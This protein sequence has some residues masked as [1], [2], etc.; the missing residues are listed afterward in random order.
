MASDHLKFSLRLLTLPCSLS[1]MLALRHVGSIPMRVLSFAML[2]Y[3]TGIHL[4]PPSQHHCK[5]SCRCI[6]SQ[7][8]SVGYVYFTWFCLIFP[9]GR[10]SHWDKALGTSWGF[11]KVY[12]CIFA[13]YTIA[14]ILVRVGWT[15]FKLL[16]W[17]RSSK[18]RLLQFWSLG[19]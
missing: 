16:I 18:Q 8:G 13:S 7:S 5:I 9:G 2:A 17:R 3:R 19:H 14:Y 12:A 10:S 1:T 11:N 15:P 4:F 6:C